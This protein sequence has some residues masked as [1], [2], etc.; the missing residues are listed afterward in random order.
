MR[1][2][3]A[4]EE[5]VRSWDAHETRRGGR[6]V[7]DYDCAPNDQPSTPATSR[8]DVF[9]QLTALHTQAIAES[10][11]VVSLTVGAHL[12]YLASVLGERPQLDEYVRTTQGCPATG[13]P[14]DYILSVGDRAK[15]ALADLGLPWGPTTDD[16]L[17]ASEKTLDL[18]QAREQVRAIAAQFEPR[19]RE[20]TGT[21][22]Q[23][24]L[25]IDVVDIDDYWAYWVDG[26]GSAARL[27]FN[28]RHA[29]FTDVR[30]RQFA[31][32]EILGHA[33]QC[34]SFAHI[35]AQRDVP[36]T[37]T[38]TVHLPY[39]ITLEGLA[40]ALP[41]FLAPD[42]HKLV[43]RVRLAHYLHLVRAELHRAINDGTSVGHCARHARSRIPWLKS[44]DIADL[45][46]D[47]GSDPLLRSYLWSYP[48]GTD[49]F[50]NLAD[51]AAPDVAQTVLREAYERPLTPC[52]LTQLWSEGPPIGG[53]GPSPA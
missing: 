37:R 29:T 35:A 39:Q 8:L 20:I 52:D 26:A 22:A 45:L 53:Q 9:D 40:T 6:A 43:A 4:V 30:L 25:S 49:W 5:L 14:E 38:L 17:K 41:L 50:V 12:A 11:E 42:D 51:N 36:W 13:W 2:R 18:E 34:A 47:R 19:L 28:T 32:H 44:A 31:Q 46:A 1:L 3:D 27:R 15:K 24:T 48:A 21:T 16:A 10:N 33:L 23:F 7:V